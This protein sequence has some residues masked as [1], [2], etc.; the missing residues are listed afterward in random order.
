MIYVVGKRAFQKVLLSPLIFIWTVWIPVDNIDSGKQWSK[1]LLYV[2]TSTLSW[3]CCQ[4]LLVISSTGKQKFFPNF[5]L[6]FVFITYKVG[7]V[8]RAKRFGKGS[9]LRNNHRFYL[10]C[11]LLTSSSQPSQQPKVQAWSL[12]Y[13]VKKTEAQKGKIDLSEVTPYLWRNR[14]EIWTRISVSKAQALTHYTIQFL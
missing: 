1:L 8:Q 3:A 7:V 6:K 5:P 11:L 4:H 2:N 12:C 9:S 13:L 10:E 14:A